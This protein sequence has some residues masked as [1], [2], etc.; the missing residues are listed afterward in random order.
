MLNSTLRFKT[1]LEKFHKSNAYRNLLQFC[2]NL[3]V[4]EF[5]DQMYHTWKLHQERQ[6]R[7]KNN[8]NVAELKVLWAVK[9]LSVTRGE[10]GWIL[11]WTVCISQMHP[12]ASSDFVS[13][14][15]LNDLINDC[16]YSKWKIPKN[17]NMLLF[18]CP[19]N[20]SKTSWDSGSGTRVPRSELIIDLFFPPQTK[21][22][23]SDRKKIS[24]TFYV[25]NVC[26]LQLKTFL[27]IRKLQ[28]MLQ[29]VKRRK[30][31]TRCDKFFPQE[32][33]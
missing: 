26:A 14:H 33:S 12:H 19:L 13:S 1:L 29:R 24:T 16:W 8:R 32:E 15:S 22:G 4:V 23:S 7:V 3:I 17:W 31:E 5:Q 11:G 2:I 9:F 20:R 25:P 28:H 30:P 27:I 6:L 10:L 21:N 18:K